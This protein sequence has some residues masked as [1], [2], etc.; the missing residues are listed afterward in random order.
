M[1]NGLTDARISAHVGSSWS[2]AYIDRD[3][4]VELRSFP[5]DPSALR[6]RL[7]LR[8]DGSLTPEESGLVAAASDGTIASRD[9]RFSSAGVRLEDRPWL[10]P[11]SAPDAGSWR[12][13][14]EILL[15]QAEEDLRAAWDPSVHVEEAVRAV[16]E[17]DGMLNLLGERI[18][19]WARRDSPEIETGDVRSL[20]RLAEE[21]I[22]PPPTADSTDVRPPDPDLAAARV[23]LARL[24]Q[25]TYNAHKALEGSIERAI[26]RRAPNVSALLGPMLAAR[27]ISHAGGLDRLARLPASTIQVLGAEKAFFEHLRGRGPPPRH[28]LLFLHADIQSAPRRQRGKLARALAGKVAIAARIDREG[29]GLEPELTRK[30][31]ERRAAIRATS[32]RGGAGGG[33]SRPPLDRAAEH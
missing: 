18:S 19:S 31:A 21:L 14:R 33:R 6:D 11:E 26:P 30:Y 2:G 17:L 12:A 7:R 3:G 25:E 28:G 24:F 13:W 15:E 8:R 20:K 5:A 27:I 32:A 29:S 4:K 10:H 1:A 16:G 22:S 9:R 23:A